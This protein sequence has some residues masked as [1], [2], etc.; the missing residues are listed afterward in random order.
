MKPHIMKKALLTS[1]AV[2]LFAFAGICS[3]S[4]AVLPYDINYQ[5]R[6]PNKYTQE[7]LQEMRSQ[8]GE[9]YQTSMINYL[10]KMSNKRKYAYLDIH[11]I[12]QVQ[13]DAMLRK[14]GIDTLVSTLT[15][16]EIAEA[17]GV[18]HV[19]RGAVTKTFIMSDEASLGLGAV[20]VLTGQPVYNATSSL[21]I[22]NTL[23]DMEMNRTSFSQ[24]ATRQ[25]K[26]TRSD[27]RAL[28]SVFR[29]SSRRIGR[30]LKRQN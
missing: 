29:Q 18:T 27:Q 2:V 16:A 23:V 1:I 11:V 12:G 21:N 8:E 15:N 19:L 14:A 26:A 5:G 30:K 3:I 6:I 17:I 4:I 13:I 28:R 24:Q 7:Q 22:T 25:T 9:N 20:G 10:T